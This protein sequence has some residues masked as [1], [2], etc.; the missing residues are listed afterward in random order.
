MPMRKL[1]VYIL[2]IQQLQLDAVLHEVVEFDIQNT[3][4]QGAMLE[5]VI[6]ACW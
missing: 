5:V 6:N 4:D 2:V 1:L 3:A